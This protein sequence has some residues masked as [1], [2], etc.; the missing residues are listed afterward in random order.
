MSDWEVRWSGRTPIPLCGH[1]GG[2]L[3]GRQ[4][5]DVVD[6]V[7]HADLG[8]RSGHVN[9]TDEDIHAILLDGEDV[10]DMESGRRIWRHRSCGS[11]PT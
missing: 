10:L 5:L 9:G 2:L 3:W 4:A 11:A 7:S 6:D 1:R 8:R